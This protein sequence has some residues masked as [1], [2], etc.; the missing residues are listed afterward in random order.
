MVW[1]CPRLALIC[2]E[3]LSQVLAFCW[4]AYNGCSCSDHWNFTKL[5]FS[6]LSD[7]QVRCSTIS[8]FLT[9][10]SS[11]LCARRHM[12]AVYVWHNTQEIH[13][14]KRT[15]GQVKK[16]IY[17]LALTSFSIRVTGLGHIRVWTHCN[18]VLSSLPDN[19]RASRFWTL[20]PSLQ[21]RVWSLL[22]DRQ[23]CSFCRLDFPTIKYQI[24]CVFC[25]TVN[26]ERFLINYSGMLL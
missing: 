15:E 9:H 16:F 13:F 3:Q 4:C 25:A 18:A 10:L 19:P 1:N 11:S 22:D 14:P 26:E 12:N 20:S 7:W 5:K 24:F 8:V 23:S 6:F 21:I 2:L 17:E